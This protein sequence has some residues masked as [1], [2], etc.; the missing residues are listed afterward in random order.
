MAVDKLVDSTQLD[1]DLTAVAGAIRQKG[2]T[3]AALAFPDGFVSAI[4]AISGGGGG[5]YSAT[6]IATMKSTGI[7]GAVLLENTGNDLRREAFKNCIGITSISAPYIT[8]ASTTGYAGYASFQGCSAATSISFP[9]L[10]QTNGNTFAQMS[11]LPVAVFPRLTSFG[12]YTFES[13]SSLSVVDAGGSAAGA[14]GTNVF[15]NC[16]SLSTLILRSTGVK[17]LPNINVFN[18][19]PFASGKAGG[20]LYVPSALISSYQSATNWSTI[21]GYS[22]NSIAAIE[23]SIYETQYADGTPIT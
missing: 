14:F 5:G 8:L 17:T 4:E 13:C 10:I 9:L 2:G 22:T 19:T 21:L 23:G 11:R 15:I 20:T 6:D 18:N 12:N 3:S 7:S 16:S 1:A